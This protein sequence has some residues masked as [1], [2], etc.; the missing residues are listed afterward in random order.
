MRNLSPGPRTSKS[1]HLSALA[2][3]AAL[4]VPMVLSLAGEPARSSKRTPKLQLWVAAY[5]YPFG[6]GLHEW[7]RLMKSARRA[8]IV[9][10]VNPNS[11][12]GTMP[13]TNY[14]AII[15]RARK[16]G[17]KLVGYVGTQYTK[18]PLHVV[19]AEVDTWV[20]FYPRIQGI[21]VDEQSS[22]AAHADYYVK[23]YQ[24]IHAKIPD[25]LVLSNPGTSCA[26]AYLSRPAA[27]G[28]FFF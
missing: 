28:I 16:A 26:P 14:V 5:Y 2:L 10:I 23:L 12:P 24:Y 18:K 9:A 7:E 6:K 19:E 20:R 11:G 27:D 25:A 22:D 13:D 4:T 21:H 15:R 1:R 17:V 3:L 8:P